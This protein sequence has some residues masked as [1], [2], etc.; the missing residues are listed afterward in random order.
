M[1]F[2]RFPMT[3]SG[4]SEEGKGEKTLERQEKRIE[5]NLNSL[6]IFLLKEI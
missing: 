1:G 6:I 4:L 3:D 5:M 2:S